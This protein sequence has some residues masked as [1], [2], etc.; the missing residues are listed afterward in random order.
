[1][2]ILNNKLLETF[3]LTEASKHFM[4]KREREKKYELCS[5]LVKNNH[6]EYAKRFWELDLNL[7]DATKETNF[8][9]AISFDDATVY[10]SDAFFNGDP[11]IFEQLDKKLDELKAF[12][13]MEHKA[14]ASS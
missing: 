2:D 11:K 7:V 14:P 3:R 10:L 1:M 8:I 5:L 6:R 12:E 4:T 9:A 13:P